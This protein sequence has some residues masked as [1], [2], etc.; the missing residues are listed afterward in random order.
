MIWLLPK[1]MYAETA[2]LPVKSI[3]SEHCGSAYNERNLVR[4]TVKK[5]FRK[6]GTAG[7][8]N[9][10]KLISRG[11]TGQQLARGLKREEEFR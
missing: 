11:P 7:R 2:V 4:I 1:T 5:T 6:R 8:R 3:H 10:C 9:V